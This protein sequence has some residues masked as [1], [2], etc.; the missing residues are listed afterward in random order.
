MY[1]DRYYRPGDGQEQIGLIEKYQANYDIVTYPDNI[2]SHTAD[3]I[4]QVIG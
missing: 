2:F 1:F 4:V 3:H